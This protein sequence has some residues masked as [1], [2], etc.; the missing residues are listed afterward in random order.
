M[1]FFIIVYGCCSISTKLSCYQYQYDWQ[2]KMTAMKWKSS[3]WENELIHSI[4]TYSL[5]LFILLF[6]IHCKRKTKIKSNRIKSSESNA[7]MIAD[8]WCLIKRFDFIVWIIFDV[9]LFAVTKVEYLFE[10]NV[11][12]AQ[13]VK[14]VCR[15][16]MDVCTHQIWI[17]ITTFSWWLIHMQWIQW[18]MAYMKPSRRVNFP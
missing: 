15:C 18:Q 7:R 3:Q 4:L 11:F 12:T 9:I 14:V 5:K 2:L 16:Q 13:K 1:Y 6:I 17:N 10:V 8:V